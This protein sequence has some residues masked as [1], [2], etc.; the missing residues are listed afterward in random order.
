MFTVLVAC[1]DDVQEEAN[2]VYEVVEEINRGTG[3]LNGVRLEAVG[4]QTD[5]TPG[6]GSDA[7]EVV[8]RQLPEDYDIFLGVMWAR[9]GTKTPRADSGTIEEFDKAVA[10]HRANPGSVRIMLYFKRAPIPIVNLERIQ[11]GEVAKFQR[12]AKEEGVLY[13]EFE[14]ADAFRRVVNR[15]LMR[16]LWA[17]LATGKEGVEA[18]GDAVQASD[19]TEDDEEL[20][21]I[22]YLDEAEE[23]M[24]KLKAIMAR[25]TTA[26]E[27]IGSKTSTHGEE[28]REFAKVKNQS[29]KEARALI[30]KAAADMES[31]T[32]QLGQDLP[33]FR[34]ILYA[35]VLSRKYASQCAPPCRGSTA[36]WRPR[37]TAWQRY[38]SCR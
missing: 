28:M 3:Q 21:Y 5:V 13:S 32:K 9:V 37:R 15:H 7:Q 36:L 20:G 11:A 29:R 8:N 16:Q 14:S 1:P 12:K 17:L 4:W 26:I 19:S 25:M 30:N 27:D 35:S 33:D 22:D 38:C 31:F 24:N 10:R 18:G 23:H 34:S 6:I 2:V